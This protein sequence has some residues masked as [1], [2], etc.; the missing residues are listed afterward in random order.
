MTSHPLVG[1][2]LDLDPVVSSPFPQQEVNTHTVYSEAEQTAAL[3]YGLVATEPQCIYF[4]NHFFRKRN[5][6]VLWIKS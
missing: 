4:Q 5:K 2:P 3:T 1:H 6:F